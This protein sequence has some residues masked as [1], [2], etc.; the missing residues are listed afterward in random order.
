MITEVVRIALLLIAIL[1]PFLATPPFLAMTKK[2]KDKERGKIILDAII[3]AGLVMSVFL[4]IGTPILDFFSISMPS[5]KVAGGIVIFIVGLRLVLGY[6][7]VDEKGKKEKSTIA[8]LLG[9]P[10]LAGPAAITTMILTAHDYGIVSSL[11]GLILA[12]A[13]TY[14][15]MLLGSLIV[16]SIGEKGISILS[17]IMGLILAAFAIEFIKSGIIAML[18]F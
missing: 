5:F 7:I 9:T 10:L 12:L 14:T 3:I 18:V 11:A 15:I 1:D 4:F 6:E 16:R 17:R 8:L 13:A 2:M